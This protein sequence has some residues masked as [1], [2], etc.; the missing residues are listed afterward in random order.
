VAELT[1][2]E[3]V[4][5]RRPRVVIANRTDGGVLFWVGK[6]YGFS[7]FCVVIA[8]VVTVV[9]SYAHFA[10]KAPPA[11]DL[12]TYAQVAPGVTR[13]YAADG[14]LLAEFASEW[15]E[16]A[17][18]DD[19]PP[20]L[21]DAFLAAEDHEFFEHSGIYFRGIMRAAWANIVAGDFAQGG[22]TITQQVA[23]QFLGAEKSLDRKAKEAITARRLEAL[24]SKQAILATYLNQ[25]FLGGSLY[26]VEAASHGYFGKRART[27]DAAF[28]T[29][30]YTAG[31]IE[32]VCRIA[33]FPP[34]LLMRD[35]ITAEVVTRI[36]LGEEFLNRLWIHKACW[37]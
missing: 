33:T 35:C 1:R 18:Y 32:R 4:P 14:T 2:E 24:Y 15:R 20:Q 19:I 13:V 31:E 27:A 5:T 21:V 30:E 37:K 7:F 34:S 12:S 16:V 28:D 8:L 11:P 25:I 3:L 17:A 26:G 23:K 10:G 6:L 36:P 29:C 9:S 22:S